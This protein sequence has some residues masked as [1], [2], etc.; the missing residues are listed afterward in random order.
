MLSIEALEASL[1]LSQL[2][3]KKG[4]VFNPVPNTPLA[5]LFNASG[6]LEQ[7]E[8][9]RGEDGSHVINLNTISQRTNNA[10]PGTDYIKHNVV[11]DEV[12][13]V[14]ADAVKGQVN[15]AR[16]VVS[17]VIQS[18]VE[19]TKIAL[20]SGAASALA[21]YRVEL[22]R[23]P[24]LLFNAPFVNMVDNLK[25]SNQSF[26]SPNNVS[27]PMLSEEEVIELMKTG[28][29]NVD[30]SIDTW[31][32]VTGNGFASM[33]WRKFFSNE[34]SMEDISTTINGHL[35]RNALVQDGPNTQDM[36]VAIFLLANKLINNPIEGS[37][38]GLA[39]LN[40]ALA[41]YREIAANYIAVSLEE[42]D[43]QKKTGMMIRGRSGTVVSVN[44][45][46][47]MDWLNQEGNCTEM[48]LG[49]LLQDTPILFLTDLES[50]RDVLC[51][52]WERHVRL[53]K[54][55]ELAE[56][57]TQ[58][59]RLL[60]G[61]FTEHFKSQLVDH[62]EFAQAV[63]KSIRD[64]EIELNKFTSDELRGVWVAATKAVCRAAYPASS[65]EEILVGMEEAAQQNPNT[66][67]RELATIVVI[68]MVARWVAQQFNVIG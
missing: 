36:A 49:T 12:V 55:S 42:I 5:E 3:D 31:L 33:V 65:A 64:F 22:Y 62:P 67:P 35:G 28:A 6:I 1:P 16:T 38:M 54:A 32:A 45:H 56:E 47:Y 61:Y 21:N 63:H 48:V 8:I 25:G 26:V 58:I 20:S 23:Y 14:A 9:E 34:K 68:R 37:N 53:V 46:M 15:F 44:E 27:F 11:M 19:K 18:I 40:T 57:H 2:A 13:A 43:N 17:P 52:N 50:K 39:N 10:F 29:R 60:L 30:S 24:E 7:S 41:A 4:L 51:D 66:D 59:K